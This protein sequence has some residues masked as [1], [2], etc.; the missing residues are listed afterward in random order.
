MAILD[1][2]AVLGV[3]VI[4]PQA[5]ANSSTGDDVGAPALAISLRALVPF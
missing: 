1:F 3:H 5:K 2:W 4:A